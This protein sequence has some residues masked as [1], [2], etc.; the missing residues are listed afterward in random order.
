MGIM[1]EGD[2]GRSRESHWDEVGVSGCCCIQGSMTFF[3]PLSH[4]LWIHYVPRKRIQGF[5]LLCVFVLLLPG[6]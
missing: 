2:V 3:C 1:G 4:F 6:P 5:S